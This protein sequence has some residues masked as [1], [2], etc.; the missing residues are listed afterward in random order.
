MALVTG[1]Y[2]PKRFTLILKGPD[3]PSFHVTGF[4]NGTFVDVKRNTKRFGHKVGGDGSVFFSKSPDQTGTIT[5]T[6]GVS[7]YE[8]NEI[9]NDFILA[10]DL[11]NLSFTTTAN[12]LDANGNILEHNEGHVCFFDM[13]QTRAYSEEDGGPNREYSLIVAQLI[14]R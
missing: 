14:Q 3:L 10:Q 6:L 4:A 1:L 9:I 12:L 13:D 2:D 11:D 5:F 8:Q 7:A